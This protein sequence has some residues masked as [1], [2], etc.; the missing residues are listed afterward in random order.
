MTLNG[1]VSFETDDGTTVRIN[2]PDNTASET[3]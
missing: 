2:I 1:D 3:E